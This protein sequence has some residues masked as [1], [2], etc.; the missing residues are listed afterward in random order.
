MTVSS[1]GIL[2]GLDVTKIISGLMAVERLP[3]ERL[4]TQKTTVAS[5]I[6]A[7]GQVK[8]AIASLQEAAADIAKTSSL[9][10]YKGTLADTSIAT[11]T[12]TS[13]AV[14]G[15][16]SVEVEQLATNHKLQSAATVDPSAGGTL[17]IE[18]GSTA[19]GSFVPKSGTSAVGV[20]IN[21]GSSLSDV[22][23]AINEANAGVS[24]TVVNG[25]DGPQLIVT[26]DETGETNQIKITSTISGL[27]F[28]P[29]DPLA[30]GNLTQATEAK[31]AILKIDGITIANT[32]SNTV[33]D[34][35]TGVTLNLT[36]T[37][38]DA[39]TQLVISNDSSN[40]ETKLQAFVDAYNSA[41]STI[42]TL[43]KYDSTG[44]STGVLN[45]DSTV[46]SAL[47]QLRGLLSTV[48]SD[49]SSSYQ[50]L[51]ELGVKSSSDGT[52]S[53]DTDVLATA[54]TSD[55]A[56]VAKTVAAYGTAF[57][58]L[59][60]D[61]NDSEDGLITVRIDGLNTTS[62]NLDDRIES[63]TRLLAMV[64]ARY[65][66]QFTALETLLASMDTTSTYL[67]QQLDNL[68]GSSS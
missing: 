66:S 38:D 14:A 18:I 64:Q 42:K 44:T 31:N 63:T 57:D 40:L 25:T 60:T 47:N 29:E 55:F 28:D 27:G 32:T 26:S 41:R 4:Q 39:P 24:A 30:S 54:M 45:G 17:T 11:A 36:K 58:T 35:I 61:M 16:Y 12:A 52:L 19:S 21:A 67:T 6:S 8:S 7:M 37:N 50:F 51:S 2:S 48:P 59:T 68:V 43:S 10:S 23:T 56:S 33:T 20:T 15:T 3:L 5:K 62:N 46:T 65:E 22:A 53:L 49:A 1:A 9:Y 34:A 13:S